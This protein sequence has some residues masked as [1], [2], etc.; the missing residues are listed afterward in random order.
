MPEQLLGLL[1]EGRQGRRLSASKRG[2]RGRGGRGTA[3]YTPLHSNLDEVITANNGTGG[4]GGDGVKMDPLY[5]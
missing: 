4:G 3:A 1:L 5:W 2:G